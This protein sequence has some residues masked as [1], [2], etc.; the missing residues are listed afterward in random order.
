LIDILKLLQ[1]NTILLKDIL[2]TTGLNGKFQ[3]KNAGEGKVVPHRP[4]CNRRGIEI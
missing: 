3:I 1:K 2:I 4:R